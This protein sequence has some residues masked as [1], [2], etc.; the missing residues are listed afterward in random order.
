M[1]I[2]NPLQLVV[3][4]LVLLRRA[5][6]CC[7]GGQKRRFPFVP[8][9]VSVSSLA[10]IGG[11]SA[12]SSGRRIFDVFRIVDQPSP[13]GGMTSQSRQ[14]AG[15]VSRVLGVITDGDPVMTLRVV[16]LE[17]QSQT[18]ST[19]LW[20]LLR[21]RGGWI[22]CCRCRSLRGLRRSHYYFVVRCRSLP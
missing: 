18:S 9:T 12:G 13:D 16:Q 7:C 2:C 8:G 22:R 19:L 14:F 3:L 20:L 1:S 15:T 10:D 11:G 17:K 4:L 21:R 6:V 5:R